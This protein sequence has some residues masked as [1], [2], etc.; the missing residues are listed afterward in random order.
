MYQAGNTNKNVTLLDYLASFLAIRKNVFDPLFLSGKLFQQILIDFWIMVETN[1]LN[2]HRFNRKVH[3]E[4]IS[5]VE[6]KLK[7]G[8]EVSGKRVILPE[9]YVGSK[10][11]MNHL[12]HNAM[13]VVAKLGKPD[14]FITMTCNPNW[15]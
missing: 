2:F 13:S 12:Y 15:I 7:D 11:Y 5:K 3:I 1:N 4:Q 8:E 6:K 10:R 14:L 9:S